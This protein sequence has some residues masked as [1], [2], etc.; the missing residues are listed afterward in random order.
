MWWRLILLC[1]YVVLLILVARILDVMAYLQGGGSGIATRLLDPM[2]LSVKQLT[3]LLD[4][5]GVSYAGVIEKQELTH[6]VNVSGVLREAERTASQAEKDQ[7]ED[8][9][10]ATNFTCGSHFF[11]EVEDSKDSVWVIE[12]LHNAQSKFMSPQAWKK[13]SKR[14]RRFGIRL[15]RFYCSKDWRLCDRKGWHSSRLVMAMPQSSQTK[16]N[17]VLLGYAGSTQVQPVF[18]WVNN[19]LASKIH[20]IQRPQELEKSWLKWNRTTS[21][22]TEN[23]RMIFLSDM[24]IPP[25]FFSVLSVK[26]TGR[27]KFGSVNIDSAAGQLLKKELNLNERPSYVI[28]TEQGYV[29]FGS[30]LGEYY[31]VSSL[32]LFLRLLHPEV[33]DLFQLLLLIVNGACVLTMCT[34]HGSLVWRLVAVVAQMIQWNA[35]LILLWLPCLKLTGFAPVQSM[36]SILLSL[37]RGACLTPAASVLRYDWLTLSAY[38]A[39]CLVGSMLLFATV[40]G[41]LQY[42]SCTSQITDELWWSAGLSRFLGEAAAAHAQPPSDLDLELGM[43]LY[44]E[45]LATPYMY[46][47]PL[48][49]TDYIKELPV[50]RYSNSNMYISDGE[51]TKS[52]SEEFGM[53]NMETLTRCYSADSIRNLPYV[54]ECEKCNALK[55]QKEDIGKSRE[56]IEQEKQNNENETAK[57]LMD[58]DY[59][60]TCGGSDGRSGRSESRSGTRQR[61]RSMSPLAWSGSWVTDAEQNELDDDSGGVMPAGMLSSNECSIC[62]EVYR[63]GSILAGLPCAHSFHQN[64]IVGWLTRDNHVCPICRWPSYRSKPCSKHA[65]ED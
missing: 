24:L 59:R 39:G 49:S 10:P 53:V 15:G 51:G 65:K 38:P 62:L 29:S 37:L 42:Y 40:V 58:G 28:L 4:S 52:D 60:C 41:V 33:N 5:R 6:L 32:A 8:E 16:E 23:I 11:E 50:W 14:T 61:A 22:E 55:R 57:F 34:I 26:F 43:D 25:M 64:C 2:A 44:I 7:I 13:L 31:S 56:D 35:A 18:D 63:V 46:L 27:V 3:G 54:F 36:L 30:G 20:A 21:S 9:D 19:N 17:V 45:R 48:I 12:V 47:R 1:V